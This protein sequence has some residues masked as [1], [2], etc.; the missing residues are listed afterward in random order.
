[1]L[2]FIRRI[3]NTLSP[4]FPTTTYTVIPEYHDQTLEWHVGEAIPRDAAG[5]RF[6]DIVEVQADG[7]ELNHIVHYFPNLPRALTPV[8]TWRQPWAQFIYDNMPTK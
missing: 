1:M 2:Y 8:V 5:D 4:A 3:K 7:D 6:N